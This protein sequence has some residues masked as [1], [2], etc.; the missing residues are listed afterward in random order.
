[1]TTDTAI[2]HLEAFIAGGDELGEVS[3]EDALTA[4]RTIEAERDALRAENEKVLEAL[5]D[6]V[7]QHCY[8]GDASRK[9]GET[10]LMDWAL[11][12]NEDAIDLLVEMGYLEQIRPDKDWWRWTQKSGRGERQALAAQDGAKQ[13]Q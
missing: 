10:V 5:V 3:K 13:A 9:M 6:M 2:A 4:L 8:F 7:G 12:A 1:M 11:S